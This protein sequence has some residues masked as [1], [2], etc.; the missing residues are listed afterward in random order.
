MNIHWGMVG[1][2]ASVLALIVTLVIWGYDL[3]RDQKSLQIVKQYEI[4][5]LGHLDSVKGQVELL[6]K[7]TPVD[8]LI[9]Y[10]ISIENT[11]SQPIN[12]RDYA[13][14]I[15]LVFDKIQSIL[16]VDVKN[17]TPEGLKLGTKVF[18]LA[19]RSKKSD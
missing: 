19:L 8:K 9:I 6:Y 13:E 16:S 1:G 18:F 3:W 11:G 15:S 5:P 2:V 17:V 7:D 14:P 10:G 4:K 12:P